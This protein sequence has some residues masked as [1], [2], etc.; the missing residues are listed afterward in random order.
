[1]T[2]SEWTLSEISRLI[3]QPQHR[4]I[5]LCEKG[6]VVP[7]FSDAHGRGSSRKFSARNLFEISIA[8]ILSEFH[9]PATVS[10]NFIYTIRSFETKVGEQI[11]NFKLPY[12]LME[13]SAPEIVGMITDGVILY[14]AIGFSGKPKTVYGGIDISSSSQIQNTTLQEGCSSELVILSHK[15][16]STS[17]NS[18]V[19]R[20]EINLTKVAQNLVLE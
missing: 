7:D 4:L 1:M 12:A 17:M 8:L 16:E 20:F 19:A 13:D 3:Q 6:V 18:N 5:Y 14:F 9:F 2:K 15:S 10:A 11:K